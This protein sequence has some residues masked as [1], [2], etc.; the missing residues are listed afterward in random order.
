MKKTVLF[1]DGANIFAATKSLRFDVDYGK[2][3]KL[4][5][6]ELLRAYYYTATIEDSQE[7]QSIRPLIDW[8]AYNGFQVVTKPTKRFIDEQGREKIK[9][10]MDKEI[11]VD[12][13]ELCSNNS[14]DRVILF[15]GDGDFKYLVQAVQRK[16]VKCDVVSTIQTTPAMCADELRRVADEFFDLATLAEFIRYERPASDIAS[17]K[18]RYSNNG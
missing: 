18:S 10:N 5:S 6:G 16:G 13:L 4:Y 7:F 11:A 12:M 3:L 9:G 14:V 17:R 1:I 2:L 15:S 8:L